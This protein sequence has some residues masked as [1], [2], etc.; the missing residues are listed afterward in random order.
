MIRAENQEESFASCKHAA[1]F[2][3]CQL[4]ATPLLVQR[5]TANCK[6]RQQKLQKP[7]QPIQT[8]WMVRM[9]SILDEI[10]L[11][12]RW[13]TVDP[14]QPFR[15]PTPSVWVNQ[16]GDSVLLTRATGNSLTIIDPREGR[17]KLNRKQAQKKFDSQPIII[18]TDVGLHTPKKQFGIH[19]LFPYIKRYRIQLI[20][21][22]RRAFN[23]LFACNTVA[24][25]T[26]Y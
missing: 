16:T 5:N 6:T 15:I 7:N 24:V 8:P 11:A 13:I 21:V 3:N 12:V 9:L 26:N 20:E 17:V 23:Q 14:R 18:S 2:I 1:I 25:P 10:G 22:F 19:W 4:D